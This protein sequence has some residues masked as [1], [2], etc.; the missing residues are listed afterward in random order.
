V[1]DSAALAFFVENRINNMLSNLDTDEKEFE[2][3]DDENLTRI[4]EGEEEELD[5]AVSTRT[6]PEPVT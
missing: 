3:G 4:S 2:Q 5:I 6:V 1:E